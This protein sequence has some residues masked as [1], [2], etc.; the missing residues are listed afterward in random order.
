MHPNWPNQNN[1]MQMMY[2]PQMMY[3]QQMM[4]NPQMIP[5]MQGNN[6]MPMN[7]NIPAINNMQMNN[8]Q[9]NNMQMNNMQNMMNQTERRLSQEFL[10]CTNDN[11]LHTI[12]CTFGLENNNYYKWKVSMIGPAETPY[13]GGVFTI[14]IIFPNDYPKR[15]AE[16]R[17]VNQIYHVN[18]DF[19]PNGQRGHICLSNLNEWATTGKVKTK[20]GYAVKQA[21]FDIFCLFYNQGV[22][23][24]YDPQI[25]KQYRDNPQQFNEIARQWTKKYA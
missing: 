23:S 13:E 22:E 9:M 25:A 19:R 4:Y 12:G 5:T 18:V 24:P 20:K 17:F 21:L 6:N 8:M 11:D 1:N 14:N 15:G 3:N 10:L 16:F 7:N 2:N